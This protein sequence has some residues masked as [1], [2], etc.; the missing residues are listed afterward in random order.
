M[1]G[2]RLLGD[3]AGVVIAALYS[4]P[5][6]SGIHEWN[7]IAD[8]VGKVDLTQATASKQ[9][10]IPLGGNNQSDMVQQPLGGNRADASAGP[11][12]RKSTEAIL[13]S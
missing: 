11:L 3:L 13:H 6:F 4:R 12:D 10:R 5:P 2:L 8:D 7:Q 1:D 9:S